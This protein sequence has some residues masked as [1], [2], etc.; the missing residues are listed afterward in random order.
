MPINSSS[1]AADHPAVARGLQ[2]ENRDHPLP[3]RDSRMRIAGS[4]RG[5]ARALDGSAQQLVRCV[6]ADIE[7]GGGGEVFGAFRWK[8]IGENGEHERFQLGSDDDVRKVPIR[9]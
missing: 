1:A 4:R 8:T 6:A 7:S 9:R 2:A 3:A 5:I